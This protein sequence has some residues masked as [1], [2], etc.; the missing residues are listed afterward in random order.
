M[1]FSKFVLIQGCA[2]IEY[3]NFDEAQTAIRSLDGS[4]LL[5]QTIYVDWAFSNGSFKCRNTKR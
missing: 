1:L 4:D 2:L 3:E 5:M